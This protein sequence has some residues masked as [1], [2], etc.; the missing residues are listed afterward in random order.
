MVKDTKNT[1]RPLDWHYSSTRDH[2]PSWP[3]LS[4]TSLCAVSL[5]SSGSPTDP[6]P[7][8]TSKSWCFVTR[9][10]FSNVTARSACGIDQ[11]IERFSLHSHR[12]SRRAWRAHPQVL[13][14]GC[15]A[16]SPQDTADLSLLTCDRSRSNRRSHCEVSHQYPGPSEGSLTT[17]NTSCRFTD[18]TVKPGIS[19]RPGSHPTRS[20]FWCLTPIWQR[21]SPHRSMSPSPEKVQVETLD[22]IFGA[23][24][25][26]VNHKRVERLMAENGIPCQGR[27]AAE[28]QNHRPR[29]HRPTAARPRAAGLLR[30]RTR[31]ACLWGHHLR[32]PTRAGSTWPTSSI[33]DQGASSATRWT[34]GCQP[35]WWPE[36]CGWRSMSE[37]AT[38][39]AWSSTMTVAPSTCPASSGRCAP[40]TRSRSRSGGSGRARTTQSRS[41]SGRP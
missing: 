20:T 19:C 15:V 4:S 17:S 28:G 34:S 36:R 18:T 2:Y 14:D 3:S 9:S 33:S 21:K 40:P 35:S 39:R 38:P 32:P 24:R 30:R 7:T 11:P 22:D 8:R 31:P 25:F 41:R 16:K 1:I 29:R 10:G 27:S 26:G 13:R 37:V 23:H 5:A 12:P 6:R